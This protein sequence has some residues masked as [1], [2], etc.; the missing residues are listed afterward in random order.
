MDAP[1][2]LGSTDPS[3]R[4]LGPDLR[5]ALGFVRPYAGRLILVGV[6][7]LAGTALSL[8]LPWLAGE[9][10]DSALLAGSMERLVRIVLLFLAIT[11]A[12]FLLNVWSGLVY[13]RASADILFDMRLDLYRHL[14]RLSPRFYAANPLGEIVSR[15]NNDLG[16]IQRVTADAVLAW[17]SNVL[18]LVGTVGILLWLDARLFLVSLIALPPSL[19]A[20]VHYRRR[21]E[22]H[23]ADMRQRSA[24]IGSFLIETLQGMRVVVGAGAEGVEADRFRRKNDRFIESLMA[25]RWF[26]YLAGGLPGV[27]LTAGTAVVFLYGGSRVIGGVITLGTFV[28]FM[29]YQ[30]RLLSPVQAL[31][32]LYANVVTARV[33]LGRVLELRQA[34]ADVA[35]GTVPLPAARG[36]VEF[37]GVRVGHGRGDDVLRDFHLVVEPGETVALV[38]RSGSGKSTVGDL[39]LRHLDPDGGQVRLDGHDL[40]T[41]R[42]A[43][44]RGRVAT[45][46]QEPFVFHTSVGENIRYGRP[47]ASPAEVERAAHAAGLDP[48]LARLPQGLDTP[49]GERGRALSAGERQRVAL[50]RAFLADPA[51][52]VLDEA[53]GAL[54]PATEAEVLA[55]WRRLMNGRTTLL[56]THRPEPARH[57][58]RVVLLEDG[59]A[60][61]G[62]GRA[63][64][65]E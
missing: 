5:W 7:S 36:R 17:A 25:M 1:P 50:A 52:L 13:T 21:L 34:P 11:V 62:H 64:A 54:D 53:T 31:M 60:A 6:L 51:V 41:L 58:D 47:D 44:L 2:V 20:L 63:L 39:L 19:W 38:G 3:A 27:I 28:A 42:L 4:R 15:I 18:F 8:V 9:L 55:G 10:V 49:V 61:P 35:D 40:R 65:P 24:D 32:G 16:E 59:R 29:A 22:G 33:S 26:G 23:V 30:M 43:D 46:E 56:V 37:D 12:T 48:L 57:A 14:Q 45:V